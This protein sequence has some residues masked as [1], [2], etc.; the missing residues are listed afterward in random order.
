MCRENSDTPLIA[1]SS[2]EFRVGLAMP[3]IHCRIIISLAFLLSG[4]KESF[5][6]RVKSWRILNSNCSHI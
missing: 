2:A 5:I 3:D 6:P 4:N 1:D